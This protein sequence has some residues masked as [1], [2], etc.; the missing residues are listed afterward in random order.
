M[1]VAH[2]CP[3]G[4]ESARS[5]ELSGSS[6][7]IRWLRPAN[8][9]ATYDNFLARQDN[10]TQS[11]PRAADG[12]SPAKSLSETMTFVAALTADVLSCPVETL[13][14]SSMTTAPY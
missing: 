5:P 14:L 4:H 10:A 12:R 9:L 13:F 7:A 8:S 6:G 11:L 3:D 1:F 2:Y